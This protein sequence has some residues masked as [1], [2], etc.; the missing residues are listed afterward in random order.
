VHKVVAPLST[1]LG[2]ESKLSKLYYVFH[3]SILQV[4]FMTFSIAAEYP[5]ERFDNFL[6][7][8]LSKVLREKITGKVCF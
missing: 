7:V 1:F 8:P 3:S 5:E 2:G 6:R 4:E